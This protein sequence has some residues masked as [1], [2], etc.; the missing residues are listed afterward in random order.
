MDYW[1][2]I[3]T[4]HVEEHEDP[5][6]ARSVNLLGPYPTREE[7]QSALE[8]AEQRTQQWD[9]A[10]DEWDTPDSSWDRGADGGS[11]GGN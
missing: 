9:A 2:N 5:Q 8:K 7:A 10:D 11:G 4:R 1:F 6:R 3:E